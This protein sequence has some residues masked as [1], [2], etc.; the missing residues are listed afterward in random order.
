MNIINNIN[1]DF[2]KL[3]NK[4]SVYKNNVTKRN[5]KDLCRDIKQL[6]ETVTLER[7]PTLTVNNIALLIISVVVST[8][9][10]TVEEL[11]EEAHKF[12]YKSL[13]K[14]KNYLGSDSTENLLISYLAVPTKRKDKNKLSPVSLSLIILEG[15]KDSI[16]LLLLRK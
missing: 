9:N 7:K 5:Q 2:E 12:T 11:I 15:S 6:L 1:D 16:L 14:D 8:G 4:I 13:I 10:F 3:K